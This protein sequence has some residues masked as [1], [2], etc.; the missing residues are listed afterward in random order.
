MIFHSVSKTFHYTLYVYETNKDFDLWRL[1]DIAKTVKY[2][3][4]IVA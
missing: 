3:I 4:V 2:L 1:K